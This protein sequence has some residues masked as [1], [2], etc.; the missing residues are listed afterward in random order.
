MSR[1]TLHAIDQI[2]ARGFP[3]TNSVVWSNDRHY[4]LTDQWCEQENCYRRY[5]YWLTHASVSTAPEAFAPDATMVGSD[6]SPSRFMRWLDTATTTGGG[7]GRA[8]RLEWTS[9]F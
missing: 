6:G 5:V 9:W 4:L 1:M 2:D 7:Y 8:D 3:F